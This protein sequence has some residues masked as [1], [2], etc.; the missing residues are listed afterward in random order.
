M[1]TEPAAAAPPTPTLAQ[2]EKV[3][4]DRAYAE[5]AVAEAEAKKRQAQA[6]LQQSAAELAKAERLLQETKA[7]T[8][9]TAGQTEGKKET[10]VP[11]KD[12]QEWAELDADERHAAAELGYNAQLF[13]IGGTPPESHKLWELLTHTQQMAAAYLGY[14][15]QEW[16][17]EFEVFDPASSIL[18][19]MTA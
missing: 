4:A 1:S 16:D 12:K 9:R 7:E 19:A 10:R 13:D 15:Q 2:A 6:Q 8:A 5:R 3:E 18:Q 14:T 17:S 11:A